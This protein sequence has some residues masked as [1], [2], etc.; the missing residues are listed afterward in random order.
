MFECNLSLSLTDYVL[1]KDTQTEIKRYN[2]RCLTCHPW[3]NVYILTHRRFAEVSVTQRNAPELL[4][5]H[6]VDSSQA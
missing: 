3:H 1:V 5:I 2:K 4:L 6:E